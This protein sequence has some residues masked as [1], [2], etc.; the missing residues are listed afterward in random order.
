MKVLSISGGGFQALYGVLILE[1]LEARQGPLKHAFDIFCGSSAGAIVATAAATGVPMSELRDGFI[2]RGAEAFRR[3]RIV[4]PRNLLRLF[5]AARYE[6]A[7]LAA[8]IGELAG[9]ARFRDLERTLAVTATRLNDG[10]AV[11][12]EPRSHG[13]VLIREAVMASTAAPTMFPAVPVGGV[14]HADGGIFANAPDL[15]ALELALRSGADAAKVSMLSLGSM[16]ACPPL[17]EPVDPDMGV[18]D[19]LRGN[20]IFRTMIGAQAQVTSR[21]MKGL[22]GDRYLRIDADPNFP[23]R[24]D[25]ALDKADGKAVAAAIMAANLSMPELDAWTPL[26]RKVRLVQ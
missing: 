9:E 5:S 11:L 14:L 3:R 15:L 2:Q 6:T 21:M 20:R 10:A 7:P 4:N 16:N 12:F 25:V 1:E 18:L 19:W 8:L 13:D 17:G 26:G 24:S 23:L 22:L